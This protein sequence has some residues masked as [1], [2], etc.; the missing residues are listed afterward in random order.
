MGKGTNSKKKKSSNDDIIGY[1][2]LFDPTIDEGRIGR[3]FY[4]QLLKSK[5]AKE[6]KDRNVTSITVASEFLEQKCKESNRKDKARWENERASFLKNPKISGLKFP[7]L[8]NKVIRSVCFLFEENDCHIYNSNID[9]KGKKTRSNIYRYNG[10]EP[11]EIYKK[12]AEIIYYRKLIETNIRKDIDERFAFHIKYHPFGEDEQDFIFSPHK[13]VKYNG[14]SFVFGVKC[15]KGKEPVRMVTLAFDRIT[16]EPEYSADDTYIEPQEH[17]YDFLK[18]MIGVSYKW[19]TSQEPHK[20]KFRVLDRNVFCLI[21]NKPMH[22][23]QRIITPF[24]SKE[25][26][27]EGYGEFEINVIQNIE[28]RAQILHYGSS[29]QVVEPEDFKKQLAD[30]IKKMNDLYN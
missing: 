12:K 5:D 6:E 20:I 3:I 30:E 26:G 15:E 24:K 11:L 23:S 17:E 22:Q 29:I 28:L 14:R 25:E 8:L 27:G 16:Q 13:V 1:K 2:S 9:G 19:G 21:D 10:D 18:H 4:N 7:K